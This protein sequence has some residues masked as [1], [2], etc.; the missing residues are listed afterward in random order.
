MGYPSPGPW[1]RV[2]DSCT[3]TRG[4]DSGQKPTCL[5]QGTGSALQ[6]P[7]LHAELGA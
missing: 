4:Q 5:A 7:E 3:G 1:G 6:L 2:W